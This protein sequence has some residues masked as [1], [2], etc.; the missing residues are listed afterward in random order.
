VKI[1]V[2]LPEKLVRAADAAA[3]KLG[4][5]RSELCAMALR[6]FLS[7][8]SQSRKITERLNEVYSLEPA[9][10]DRALQLASVLS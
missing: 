3:R 10:V 2:T 7:K 8:Q 9:K 4:V 6:Q 5:S 1:A